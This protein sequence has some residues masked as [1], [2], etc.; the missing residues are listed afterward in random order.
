[1]EPS[2][3]P[4]ARHQLQMAMQQ[5]NFDDTDFARGARASPRYLLYNTARLYLAR[6]LRRM[7]SEAVKASR[8]T[9]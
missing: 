1:M 9:A 4:P 3:G 7:P 5:G 8:L 2:L 6:V